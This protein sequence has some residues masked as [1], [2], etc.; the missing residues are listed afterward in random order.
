MATNGKCGKKP[1]GIL[2]NYGTASSHKRCEFH[3]QLGKGE[4]TIGE[5][6]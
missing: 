3:I 6:E 4:F 5:G 1:V 2:E